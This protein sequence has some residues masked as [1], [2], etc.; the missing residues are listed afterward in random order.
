M[1]S[2]LSNF[3]VSK[4]SGNHC[5]YN[6]PR[7]VLNDRL[8]INAHKEAMA[9]STPV[10]HSYFSYSIPVSRRAPDTATL[11][12][13]ERQQQP[14]NCKFK[15]IMLDGYDVSLLGWPKGHTN[16]ILAERILEQKNPNWNKNNNAGLHGLE[17]RFVGFGGGVSE[18]QL[19]WFENELQ[20][21]QNLAE[22]VIVCCHLCLHPKTC[23]AT[24]L[25]YNFEE[26]EKALLKLTKQFDGFLSSAVC[27][28][29][30]EL[31]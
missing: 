9:S 11:S 18:E 24:C 25:L 7:H 6:A 5:L 3:C 17:R 28:F 19:E 21:S 20:K 4:Y 8:G 31:S 1:D 15:V 12:V 16:R 2:Y 22:R 30:L 10:H 13:G 14:E 23:P 27:L 26:G 29:L